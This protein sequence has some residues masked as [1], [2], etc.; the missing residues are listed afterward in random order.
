MGFVETR[1]DGRDARWAEHRIERRRELVESALRAIRREGPG[2]GM[3]DIAAEAGT[4]KPV[5]YRHFGDRVGLYLA[6]VEKVAQ[7]ILADLH[8]SVG[9]QRPDDLSRM[10]DEM[11]SSYLGLVERDPDIYRF[12][13]NR[14]LVDRPLTDDP[15]NGLTNRI[16][17]QVATVLCGHGYEPERASTL[18][19]GLVGFVRGAAAQW[20]AG[21]MTRARDAVVADISA[22]FRP[23]LTQ[24]VTVEGT[25]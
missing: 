4:S 24:T 10:V 22:L 16:G 21:G 18:G 2:V 20:V 12:V 17:D 6:V 15:V 7:N 11:A 13:I 1:I 25:A 5:L 14:P 3:D 9:W 23:A 8:T 19:H